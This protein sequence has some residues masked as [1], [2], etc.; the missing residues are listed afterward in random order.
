MQYVGF[1]RFSSPKK[2]RQG[3]F[4]IQPTAQKLKTEN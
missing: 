1:E 2:V 4:F 3:G